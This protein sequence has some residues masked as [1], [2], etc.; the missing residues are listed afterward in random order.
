MSE[1]NSTGIIIRQT[2]AP[3][4]CADK[5][6]PQSDS[7]FGTTVNKLAVPY[8]LLQVYLRSAL[9]VV[10]HSHGRGIILVSSLCGG[11]LLLH[12]LCSNSMTVERTSIKQPVISQAA[13][14]QAAQAARQ[15]QYQ[16]GAL[17]SVA[18]WD[19]LLTHHM[20]KATNSN[21]AISECR[22]ALALPGT[23]YLTQLGRQSHSLAG[24]CE[25]RCI[26]GIC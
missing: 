24:C 26:L 16:S 9:T 10:C 1:F 6:K 14:D 17:A 15:Q 25:L 2:H 19:L 20:M 18:H 8:T 22:E 7:T 4:G 23:A 5:A 21:L 3:A 13:S 12:P 11:Q